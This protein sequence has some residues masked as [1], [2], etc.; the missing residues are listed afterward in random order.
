MSH[1]FHIRVLACGVW[2]LALAP[3]PA[4]AHPATE[5]YIPIGASPGLSGQGTYIGRIRS[6]DAATH[7]LTVQSED[8]GERET[9]LITPASDMWFDSTKRGRTSQD[10]SF[11]DCRRGRRI[12]V[13]LHEGS[14]EADWVKIEGPP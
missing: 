11:K 2:L 14:R 10:A 4:A 8:D 3:V 5:R 1:R 9:I 12:E 13:K 6:V 7:T